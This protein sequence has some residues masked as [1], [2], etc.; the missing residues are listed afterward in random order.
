VS[1]VVGFAFTAADGPA[2]ERAAKIATWAPGG[3]LHLVHVFDANAPRTEAS[4]AAL[5]GRLRTYVEE[6]AA[7]MGGL[8]GLHVGIHLRYGD[9]VREILQ[10][11]SDVSATMIVVGSEAGPRLKQWIMGSTADKLVAHAPMPVLV[12]SPRGAAPPGDEALAI[13]PPC[14]D[15]TRVRFESRG[16]HWW[17]ERHASHA[18]S[19]HTYSYQREWP[20][21][22]HDSAVSPTGVDF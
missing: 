7:S 18:K 6:K 10:L 3:E 14:P 12:A 2:F 13:E 21:S 9:T 17:C 4:S 8:G 5:A 1:I 19:G 11:A 15:C 22:G 20:F 16:N